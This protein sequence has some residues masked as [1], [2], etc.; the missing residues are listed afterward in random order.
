M[1]VMPLRFA[2]STECRFARDDP[3]TATIHWFF[4]PEDTPILPHPTVFTSR[5][6]DDDLVDDPELGEV[7]GAPVVWQDGFPPFPMTGAQPCGTADMFAN[8]V[9]VYPDPGPTL[10]LYGGLECC[11]LPPAPFVHI[12]CPNCPYGASSDNTLSVSGVTPGS[13]MAPTGGVWRLSYVGNCTWLGP[14]FQLNDGPRTLVRW[15]QTVRPSGHGFISLN[16]VIGGVAIVFYEWVDGWTCLGTKTVA[17]TAG[18]NQGEAPRVVFF[19]GL[20]GAAGPFCSNLNTTIPGAVTLRVPPVLNPRVYTVLAPGDYPLSADDQCGWNGVITVLLNSL[21]PAPLLSC[22]LAISA[23]ARLRLSLSARGVPGFLGVTYDSFSGWER[24]NPIAILR[25]AAL[26]PPTY[27]LP[28]AM[29]V[30]LADNPP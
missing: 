18:P 22:R 12:H 19:P 24:V 26:P 13:V 2:Y 3:R 6:W 27:V 11:A 30:Y 15:Q 25:N 9:S 4:V 14:I 29:T 17:L 1:G 7:Q 5:M 10:N 28:D 23:I 16:R 20:P 8:G 21:V